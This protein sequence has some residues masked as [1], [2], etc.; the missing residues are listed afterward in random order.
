MEE[1]IK[2]KFYSDYLEGLKE[3]IR[4][5]SLSPI[6]DAEWETNKSLDKQCEH[7]QKF[8]RDQDLKG[9]TMHVLRDEGKTPFLIVKVEP[10]GDTESKEQVLMYGHMDKQPFG[11]GWNTDPC[12][13]V[14]IDGRLYGR[15]SS[16]DG[17]A[18]FTAVTAIKACQA[19]G[20]SHPR[21]VITIE[22]SEEGETDDLIH[23]LKTYKHL[24]D[25]PSLVICL[26]SVAFTED[27]VT[28]T[29][30]LRGCISFDLKASVAANNIHS[31]MGGGVCPNPYH[32]LNC[33]LMR[34]QDFKTQ[35]VIEE[36]QLKEIPPHRLA[37]V[38]YMGENLEHLG[39]SLPLLDTTKSM[40]H[41]QSAGDAKKENVQL[42]INSFWRSQLAVIGVEGVPTDINSAGNVIYKDMKFRCSMRIPPHISAKFVV[43]TLRE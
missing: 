22:G 35:E 23:Y 33:A 41:S 3:F 5:P 40:A 13:P 32:I 34:V 19:L 15:G 12:D 18:L 2:E 8:V 4:I 38:T 6:F 17:Y 29:S 1:Y 36:L 21:I 43:D 28:I 14:T 31:G 27:T 9:C 25:D 10:F 11:D 24:L 30:S 37:E 20:K 39:Q 42:H 7:L 16:D 26:D